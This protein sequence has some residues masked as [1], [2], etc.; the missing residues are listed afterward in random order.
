VVDRI[1]RDAAGKMR[2]SERIKEFSKEAEGRPKGA[3]DSRE[4]ETDKRPKSYIE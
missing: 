4:R 2:W 1:Q 3:V